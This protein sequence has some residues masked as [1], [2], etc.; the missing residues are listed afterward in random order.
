MNDSLCRQVAS[1]HKAASTLFKNIAIA[2][3]G[4][5]VVDVSKKPTDRT[6]PL[7]HVCTASISV[8][9]SVCLCLCALIDYFLFQW[10][11]VARSIAYVMPDCILLTFDQPAAQLQQQTYD[12]NKMM[13]DAKTLQDNATSALASLPGAQAPSE[14]DGY[15]YT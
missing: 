15:I 3:A 2:T 13:K 6:K 4:I 1:A 5:K 10:K 11:P 8:C 14:Y 12:L 7:D 9:L